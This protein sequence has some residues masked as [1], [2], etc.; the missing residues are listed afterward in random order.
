[1]SFPFKL[2]PGPILDQVKAWS[3]DEILQFSWRAAE[4]LP[5]D[6]LAEISDITGEAVEALLTEPSIALVIQSYRE[7]LE[8]SDEEF[9]EKMRPIVR[10]AIQKQV[11]QSKPPAALIF[12][13]FFC[14]EIA[15][16]DPVDEVMDALLRSLWK[17]RYRARKA[18]ETRRP[19]SSTSRLPDRADEPTH[20]ELQAERVVQRIRE[21]M[22][23]VTAAVASEAL[24]RAD[25]K[26]AVSDAAPVA[27][28]RVTLKR[29]AVAKS[30]WPS[31]RFGGSDDRSSP[32]PT[33]KSYARRPQGP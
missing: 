9:R 26:A 16:K 25:A 32:S 29:P 33:D 17:K 23:E 28:P 2:P 7:T 18:R 15:D 27:E 22:R 14:L 12:M 11:S 13:M 21:G 24:A 1:M 20:E 3:P 6:Q 30:P 19:I 5:K 4:G 31:F 10:F 8:C